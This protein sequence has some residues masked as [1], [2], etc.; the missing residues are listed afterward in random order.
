MDAYDC[1]E[2]IGWKEGS[3]R[4][5]EGWRRPLPLDWVVGQFPSA[6]LWA[7]GQSPPPRSL[8]PSPKGT[9]RETDPLPLDGP[10]WNG[11]GGRRRLGGGVF[12]GCGG[13]GWN[14][15]SW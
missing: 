6:S 5:A 9:T 3:E 12:R 1:T 7:R 4:P 10:D 2:R 13:A 14:S 11:R 8:G 15:F